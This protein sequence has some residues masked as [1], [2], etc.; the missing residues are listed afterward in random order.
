MLT[1][2]SIYACRLENSSLGILSGVESL[3]KQLITTTN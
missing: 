3:R 2:S 1:N